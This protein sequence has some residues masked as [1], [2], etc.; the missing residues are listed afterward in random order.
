MKKM[1]DGAETIEI[2]LKGENHAILQERMHTKSKEGN[3]R[4]TES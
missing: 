4:S 1:K 3:D 2:W